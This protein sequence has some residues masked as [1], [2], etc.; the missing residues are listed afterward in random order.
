MGNG[1]GETVVMC[2]R[3]TAILVVVTVIMIAVVKVAVSSCYRSRYSRHG[4]KVVRIVVMLVV[5][6]SL[7]HQI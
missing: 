2:I 5:T 7:G 1:R 6:G 4:D 3:A